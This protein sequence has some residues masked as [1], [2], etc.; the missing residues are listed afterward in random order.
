M[1]VTKFKTGHREYWQRQGPWKC[2]MTY[3]VQAEYVWKEFSFIE[4]VIGKEW[5]QVW[6]SRAVLG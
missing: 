1:A 4:S 5:L 2:R 6:K 3:N